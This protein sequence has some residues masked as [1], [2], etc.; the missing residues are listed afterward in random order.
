METRSPGPAVETKPRHQSL[1]A[2]QQSKAIS[3]QPTS[4]VHPKTS[5]ET[6]LAGP[7]LAIFPTNPVAKPP[8]NTSHNQPPASNTATPAVPDTPAATDELENW[9]DGVTDAPVSKHTATS[10]VPQSKEED[11]E[12]WLDDILDI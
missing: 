4:S 6:P 2:S 5:Q 9:L 1:H 11:L 12:K 10:Q 8:S 7:P 3:T